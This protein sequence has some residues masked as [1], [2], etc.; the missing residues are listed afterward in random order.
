MRLNPFLIVFAAALTG[1]ASIELPPGQEDSRQFVTETAMPYRDAYQLIAKQMRACYRIIG[2][3]GNGYDIQADLD[4]AEKTGKVEL[5]HV[6]LTG[7]S[8]PEDSIF[9]RTVI[10]RGT[11]KGSTVTTR[12]NTP[13]YVYANHLAV[14]SW[15]SGSDS[16]G[17]GNQR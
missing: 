1:C 2:I 6:G 17:P 16:C 7:A 14:R 12:G 8:K 4:T 5:Y 13:K 10:V 3:F 9:S 11:D 15:L